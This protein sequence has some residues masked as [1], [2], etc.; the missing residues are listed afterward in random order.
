MFSSALLI[1]DKIL[2]QR[3]LYWN[4]IIKCA[5]GNIFEKKSTV[6][7]KDTR[8]AIRR[9]FR[10]AICLLMVRI[11]LRKIARFGPLNFFFKSRVWSVVLRR[12]FLWLSRRPLT[13][14]SKKMKISAQIFLFNLE[15]AFHIS[16]YEKMCAFFASLPVRIKQVCKHSIYSRNGYF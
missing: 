5:G 9:M 12:E 16:S 15:N 3:F 14:F 8:A 2:K 7:S 1:L 4:W 11:D 6:K 13:E 10:T